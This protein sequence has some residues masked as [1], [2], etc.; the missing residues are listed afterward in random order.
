MG[1]ARGEGGKKIEE[2]VLA[3][4][5]RRRAQLGVLEGGSIV[6]GTYLHHSFTCFFPP[7]LRCGL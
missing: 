7:F 5:D 6:G 2:G 3:G 4:M 1:S